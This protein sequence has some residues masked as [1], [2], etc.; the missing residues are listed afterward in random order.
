MA[1]P[2]ADF[3]PG[4]HTRVI[5]VVLAA[6]LMGACG[7]AAVP[8]KPPPVSFGPGLNVAAGAPGR[9]SWAPWPAALHDARH[10]GASVSLGPTKGA[11]RWRRQL[12]GAVTPGPVIGS[13]GTIY[14]ASN[15]GVL[16]ALNPSTGTDVWTYDSRHT[17]NGDD[18]SVSVLILQDGTVVW[19][20]PGNELLALSPSGV[21]L[22]SRTLPGQPTSPASI[23]GHRIYIGDTAGFVTALDI[24]D[25]G[26]P[27]QV[28]TVKVGAVSYGSVVIG[29]AG[30]LYT[31]ADSSLVAID[32]AGGQA[33]IAWRADP[34]DNITEVS[35]GLAADGTVL[36]GTNGTQEWA[37]GPDGTPRW[38][39]PRVITYSSPSVT[40]SG[41]AYVGDHSGTVHVIRVSDGSEVASYRHAAAQIWTSTIVDAS[42]H[43]YYATQAGHIIGLDPNGATLFDVDVG[44][45][46]DCYP[47]LTADANLI[48]GD[49]S[50][51]LMS[52]G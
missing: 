48:I 25:N 31:T 42:Y 27:N 22:W 15:G 17:H 45:P 18:L 46:V 11:V 36:L 8:R 28:W 19:P 41:L 52:I 5:A 37:Y 3:A 35:A 2:V 12:E 21:K 26:A 24:A 49:R 33:R 14:A 44:A 20:T 10:S 43:L 29:G 30:R 23:D 13:D 1:E 6:C 38:H 51:T 34:G 47:A 40:E 32:D 39:S 16:H 9:P 50:G 4:W 7:C